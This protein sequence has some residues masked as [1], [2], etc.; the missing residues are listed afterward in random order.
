M[1]KLSDKEKTVKLNP[2]DLVAVSV[3]NG[4]STF[5]SKAVEFQN[6]QALYGDAGNVVENPSFEEIKTDRDF[7]E[8]PG[9]F[10]PI[11]KKTV[12][13]GAMPN[14][15]D[16]TI[17]H[18]IADIN[19]VV[20]YHGYTDDG[21]GGFTVLPKTGAANNQYYIYV[22]VSRSDIF[23]R[24][25]DDRSAEN[26]ILTIEYTKTTDTPTS[27]PRNVKIGSGGNFTKDTF[28]LDTR[29]SA[30]ITNI[31]SGV[32]NTSVFDDIIKDKYN[33]YNNTTGEWTAPKD[34]DIDVLVWH[35]MQGS[36]GDNF[37]STIM[38]NGTR[39]INNK[40]DHSG[41]DYERVSASLRLSVEQGDIIKVGTRNDNNSYTVEKTESYFQITELIAGTF[42]PSNIITGAVELE[43]DEY[44]CDGTE[45]SVTIDVSKFDSDDL[46]I[47]YNGRGDNSTDNVELFIR[48]NGD[49][50]NNYN[51]TM[52][53][54]HA[55][56]TSGSSSTDGVNIDKMKIG[57]LPAANAVS[58]F[59]GGGIVSFPNYK[60]TTFN[61]II[62]SENFHSDQNNE[63]DTTVVNSGGLW[64]NSSAITSITFLL[65][66]GNFVAGS[67]IKIYG[68]QTSAYPVVEGN[69]ITV[70]QRIRE[71]DVE[72]DTDSV[73]FAGLDG[74]KDIEYKIIGTVKQSGGNASN[75]YLRLNND[76]SS[77]NYNYERHY[78][79]GSTLNA[80]NS[81]ALPGFRFA[82]AGDG[83]YSR[84]SYEL[85]AKTGLPRILQGTFAQSISLSDISYDI[86]YIG[87]WENIDDNISSMTIQLDDGGSLIGSHLELWAVRTVKIGPQQAYDSEIF[88]YDG[89]AYGSTNN[90]IPIFT[91]V[92]RNIGDDIAYS[93]SST[94]G[95]SFII[96]ADGIYAMTYID[97]F[98]ADTGIGISLNSSELTTGIES[99]AIAD[100]L[101]SVT[102]AS[103]ANGMS[104]TLH[105]SKGDV[106]RPHTD[107]ATRG[108]TH[109]SF[110]ITR[111]G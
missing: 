73:E 49:T 68:K 77:A 7:E 62:K 12:D 42:D 61:K 4:D 69:E 10:R 101:G 59:S 18:N 40:H 97:K 47:Y 104:V 58:G 54:C 82:T 89:T 37:Y 92:D 87:Q 21:N 100:R 46:E 72:S 75:V 26:G 81:A 105:L 67:R 98:S 22:S 19:V 83:L 25:S 60:N 78:S 43:N 2:T 63:S 52:Q 23:F 79:S 36:E 71:I 84:F 16:K 24:T 17:Q 32:W 53:Y 65:S 86:D 44:I 55:D 13:C 99:I 96:N 3:D 29:L 108:G 50:G 80:E 109:T 15:T 34:V 85:Q 48:V 110:R 11:Y 102:A 8:S 31:S 39:M 111:I 64:K 20:S 56:G 41:S 27:T 5:T 51:N 14:N 106:V 95:D 74:D 6:I 93:T 45:S 103:N 57:T 94:D 30:D 1:S 91:T 90:K 70:M 28:I 76:A 9:S 107:G 35:V 38:L 33:A 66:S 88:V